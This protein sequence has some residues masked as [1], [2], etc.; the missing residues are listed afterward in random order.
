MDARGSASI[1]EILAAFAREVS[2]TRHPATQRRVAEARQRLDRFLDTDAE[3]ALTP[4]ERALLT[5]ER[6]FTPAG[7]L[8]RVLG[9]PT[10]L[11]ALPTF[12]APAWLPSHPLDAKAQVRFVELLTD[13]VVADRRVA[14]AEAAT[15]SRAVAEAARS[16]RAALADAAR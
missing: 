9:A 4:D 14:L 16:V 2:I 13:R 12:L 15:G 10:L 1:E 3:S 6:Q 7:A 11:R 8:A 5:A